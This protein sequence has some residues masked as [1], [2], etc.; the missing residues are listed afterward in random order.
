VA[1]TRFWFDFDLQG[2]HRR[3]PAERT[4]DTDGASVQQQWLSLGAGVTAFDEA[5]ALT[6]LSDVVGGALPPR[7]RTVTDVHA[8]RAALGI[9]NT[10]AVGNAA[11]R[12]V[13]FPL[14]NPCIGDGR[15][16]GSV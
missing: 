9:P 1:L 14:E 11:W 12:G 6:L 7:T 5:D 16:S 8:D 4:T 3:A 15:M 13:W 10:R 2:D